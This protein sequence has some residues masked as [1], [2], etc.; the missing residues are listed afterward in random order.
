MSKLMDLLYPRN[1]LWKTVARG[2]IW[3]KK[4]TLFPLHRTFDII[5]LDVT[6][7]IKRGY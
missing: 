7:A 1:R 4:W 6:Q 3:A 2:T 5:Y